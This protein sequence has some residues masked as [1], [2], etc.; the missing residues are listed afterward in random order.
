MIDART[1]SDKAIEYFKAFFPDA[2]KVHL[3]EVE[4]TDD[5]KYW[6]VTVG[7]DSDDLAAPTQLII[8]R[9]NKYKVFKVDADS[10]EI[11]SMK[12][13]NV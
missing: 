11:L 1:A 2:K 8:G 6:L 9:S 5:K 7:Y 4:L 10:A 12:L 3:E 13:R